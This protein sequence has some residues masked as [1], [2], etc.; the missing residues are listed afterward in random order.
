M[1]VHVQVLCYVVNLQLQVAIQP[2]K[3]SFPHPQEELQKPRHQHQKLKR[4]TDGH[5]N[6]QKQR[7]DSERYTDWSR[8]V[9]FFLS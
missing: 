2:A 1:K 8:T 6:K 7:K 5:K 3:E 9:A 4:Q